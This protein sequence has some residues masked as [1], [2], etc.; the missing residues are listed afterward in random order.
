[1]EQQQ[2]D[3]RL[4]IK[5][6]KEQAAKL[7]RAVEGVEASII[8]RQREL[9]QLRDRLY[10]VRREYQTAE[11][12]LE[13]QEIELERWYLVDIDKESKPQYCFYPLKICK[14]GKLSGLSINIYELFYK[15]EGPVTNLDTGEQESLESQHM[16]IVHLYKCRAVAPK[17]LVK[18]TRLQVLVQYGDLSPVRDHA[19]QNSLSQPAYY[20]KVGNTWYHD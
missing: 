3:V 12:I 9:K 11:R 17:N 4:L 14:D 6:R 8:D 13:A 20:Y 18:N 5:Q 15:I 7:E 19:L 1:M 16:K 10:Q 2:T